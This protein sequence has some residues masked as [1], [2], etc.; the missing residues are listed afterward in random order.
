MTSWSSLTTNSPT[1]S[2]PRATCSTLLDAAGV[3]SDG[4]L[5]ALITSA[6]VEDTNVRKVIEFLIYYGVLVLRTEDGD[7]YIY[8][9]NYNPKMIEARVRRAGDKAFYVVNPAFWPALNIEPVA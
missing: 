6:G 5:R 3:M 8:R 7:L 4:E 1:S 9:V 2:P